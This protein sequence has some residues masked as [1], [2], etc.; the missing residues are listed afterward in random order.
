MIDERKFPRGRTGAETSGFA[1]D[2][3]RPAHVRVDRGQLELDVA[4]RPARTRDLKLQSGNPTWRGGGGG[5]AAVR[6]IERVVMA[7]ERPVIRQWEVGG[8]DG[9]VLTLKVWYN[10]SCRLYGK[11]RRMVTG[12]EGSDKAMK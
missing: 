5:R 11:G 10:D 6:S 12:I 9:F 3:Q 7:M 2:A 1:P 8:Y 4:S